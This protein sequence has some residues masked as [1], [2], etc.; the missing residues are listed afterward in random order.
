MAVKKKKQG[1]ALEG[2]RALKRGITAVARQARDLV[3]GKMDR[4]DMSKAL[5]AQRESAKSRREVPHA[6]GEKP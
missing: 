3:E 1:M 6:A 2:A 5:K 4:E